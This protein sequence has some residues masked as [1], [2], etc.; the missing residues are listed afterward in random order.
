MQHV[1][2]L[3]RSESFFVYVKFYWSGGLV[4][5]LWWIEDGKHRKRY[6]EA[7]ETKFFDKSVKPDR[8]NS[9]TKLLKW[10]DANGYSEIGES[11]RHAIP[12]TY[13]VIGVRQSAD[14]PPHWVV[15]T[16]GLHHD[17]RF[18]VLLKLVR[19][20]EPKLFEDDYSIAERLGD[21]GRAVKGWF[22]GLV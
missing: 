5:R 20:E 13:V 2:E 22:G 4:G 12:S 1:P 11:E 18:N 10:C 19:A 17:P 8:K 9:L 3:E 6:L 7:S 15:T 14:Q 21:I 16:G